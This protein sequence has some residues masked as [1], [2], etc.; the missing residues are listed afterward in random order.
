MHVYVQGGEGSSTVVEHLFAVQL[1]THLQSH[2]HVY[3]QGGEGAS[4]S[5][6]VLESVLCINPKFHTHVYVQGGEGASTSYSG[7]GR[8]GFASFRG[9]GTAGFAG[10]L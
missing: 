10:A 6:K 8:P 7:A 4:T 5:G 1:C 2:T 9:P 3:V